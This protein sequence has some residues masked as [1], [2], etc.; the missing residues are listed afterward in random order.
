MI[1]LIHGKWQDHINLI[2]EVDLIY[3]QAQQLP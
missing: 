3:S 1:K 2:G